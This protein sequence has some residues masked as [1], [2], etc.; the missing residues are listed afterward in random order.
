LHHLCRLLSAPFQLLEEKIWERRKGSRALEAP[1]RWLSSSSE[2]CGR[3]SALLGTSGGTRTETTPVSYYRSLDDAACTAGGY[4]LLTWDLS[5]PHS[6][7]FTML[8]FKY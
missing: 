2:G 5:L 8:T 4:E 3:S 1:R 6:H 7:E